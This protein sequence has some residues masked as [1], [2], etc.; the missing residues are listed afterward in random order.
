VTGRKVAY[1]FKRRLGPNANGFFKL[2][3]GAQ[4]PF[5]L[6]AQIRGGVV[7]RAPVD[8]KHRASAPKLV[9]F[10]ANLPI[11][12]DFE[13]ALSSFLSRNRVRAQVKWRFASHDKSAKRLRA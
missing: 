9:D 13:G 5:A 7:G 3:F 12:R 4:K 11:K 6:I 8:S 10:D 2:T 1:E